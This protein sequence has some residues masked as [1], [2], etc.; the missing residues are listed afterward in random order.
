MKE[1]RR[2]EDH[3]FTGRTEFHRPT[4]SFENKRG[5]YDQDWQEELDEIMYEDFED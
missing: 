5:R 1:D 2:S 4:R 3:P